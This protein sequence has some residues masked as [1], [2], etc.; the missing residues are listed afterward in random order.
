[1]AI[2][3]VD[4]AEENRLLLQRI[5]RMSGY[6][7][8][9][10]ADS[11]QEAFAQLGI[12]AGTESTTD[13]DLILMDVLM[14]DI[15]GIRACRMIKANDHLKD[16]PVLM[17]TARSEAEDLQVAFAA[18]ASD[19]I[20]K[21]V[22]QVVLQARVHHALRLKH[23]M[24]RRKSR[25]KELLETKGLLEEANDTLRRLATLDPIT[26]IP[27][28]RSFET[29]LEM[30]WRRAFRDL[31]PLSLIL[32]D[33]DF[34]KAFN[35]TYGHQAGDDC[36]RR[37]AAC[38]K[39]TVNRSSDV[40]ARYG[41]EEMAV[42]LPNTD[43]DGAATVAERLRLAVAGLAIEHRTSSVSSTVTVS[44]GVATEIPARDRAPHDVVAEADAA[45]YEAKREGRDR[46]RQ[47]DAVRMPAVMQQIGG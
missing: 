7:D 36:L 20:N 22:D 46:V 30:E 47:G 38:L 42:L 25:E 3:I 29:S 1:M 27:N 35:D 44:L 17:V 12:R 41:G 28:R 14:P 24:D 43:A 16:I 23:E 10:L 32:I 13:I 26:G 33:I 34:F 40:V 45:L 19:Y 11:A 39:A 21:P 9:R 37:I 18:G 2:L 6:A 5:L 8:T 4:D 31:K 15:D